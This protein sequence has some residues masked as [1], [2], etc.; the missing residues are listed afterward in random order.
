[1]RTFLNYLL[2]LISPLIFLISIILIF[3]VPKNYYSDLEFYQNEKIKLIDNNST[4]FFG[5]SSCG[6]GLDAEIYGENTYN[7]SLTGPHTSCGSLS[8]LKMILKNN[9][10][11]KAYFMFSINSYS[12][13]LNPGYK[14][15]NNTNID[16]FYIKI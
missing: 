8:L 15:D 12:L 1:M 9:K 14:I 16:Y 6:N 4:I 3:V 5:D 13:S 2:S 11:K 10:I 7:M